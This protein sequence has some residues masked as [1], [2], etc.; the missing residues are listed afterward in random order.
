V[1]DGIDLASG[2]TPRSLGSPLPE[3]CKW[4]SI[5]PG[6]TVY[7]PASMTSYPSGTAALLPSTAPNLSPSIRMSA[8]STGARPVPSTSFPARTA[9]LDMSSPPDVFAD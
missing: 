6:I 4:Q 2:E 1:N 8:F 9:I 7:L 3:M 5:R